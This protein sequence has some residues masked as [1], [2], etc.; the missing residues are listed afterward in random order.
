M[1]YIKTFEDFINESLVEDFDIMNP[2]FENERRALIKFMIM[3]IRRAWYRGDSDYTKQADFHDSLLINKNDKEI[4]NLSPD[5]NKL[6]VFI[7]KNWRN[8]ISPMLCDMANEIESSKD[9]LSEDTLYDEFIKRINGE[10]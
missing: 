4:K 7:K 6:F 10:L 3:F 8:V 1:G 2:N 9:N 5:I